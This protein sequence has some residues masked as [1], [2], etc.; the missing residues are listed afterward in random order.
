MILFFFVVR[1]ISGVESISKR[2]IVV[3]ALPIPNNFAMAPPIRGLTIY[4]K[5]SEM[6]QKPTIPPFCIEEDIS[7]RKPST[8]GLANAKPHVAKNAESIKRGECKVEPKTIKNTP[9]RNIPNI[10]IVVFPTLSATIPAGTWKIIKGRTN[11][12]ITILATMG[13]KMPTEYNGTKAQI[14]PSIKT[15]RKVVTIIPNPAEPRL[16]KSTMLR[17]YTLSTLM[18]RSIL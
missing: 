10:K 17:K 2:P 4:A 16:L 9:E 13:L 18:T 7:V 5:S 14:T 1:Y 3:N 15:N 6:F 12:A 11:I 8:A